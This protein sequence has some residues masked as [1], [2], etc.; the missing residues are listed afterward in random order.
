[1]RRAS[2]PVINL[3]KTE[4]ETERLARVTGLPWQSQRTA[5][6]ILFLPRCDY[7]R[8]SAGVYRVREF[9]AND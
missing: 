4:D 8:Y 6:F 2:G 7:R 3:K 1:V 9:G 5:P